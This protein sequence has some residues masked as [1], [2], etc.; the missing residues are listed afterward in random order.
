MV[1]K[2]SVLI[3]S[4]NDIKEALEL[5][6]DVY[7]IADDIV[8]V[9]SSDNNL[10][11]RLLSSRAK[12]GLRKLR[13]FY[14]IPIGYP[15]PLRMYALKKCRYEWVL[16]LDTD[17]RLSGRGKEDVKELISNTDAS[18]FAIKRY[19]EFSGKAPGA[20][21]TWQQR[22]FRKTDVRFRGIVHERPEVNG[23]VEKA[24]DDFYIGPFRIKVQVV[25]Y[26]H[27]IYLL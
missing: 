12:L 15:D 20:F 3:F 1:G 22:L 21:F 2:L 25:R 26:P 14:T 5:I 8:L 10:H 7:G 19:E 11:K 13:I 18:A 27:L 6:E 9:D 16:L 17:E 4:R 24:P 23:I